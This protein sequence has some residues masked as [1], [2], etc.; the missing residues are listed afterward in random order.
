MLK[1]KTLILLSALLCL[2][3]VCTACRGVLTASQVGDLAYDVSSLGNHILYVK[4]N[5]TYVPFL[6]MTNDFGGN[7]LLLREEIMAQ[8]RPYND[9]YAAYEDS[10][11]DR[12]L[13]TDYLAALDDPNLTVITTRIEVTDP[14]SLGRSGRDTG[15]IDR[16]VFILSH[17]ELALSGPIN[18]ADEGLPLKYFKNSASR[19][20]YLNGE[21]V[22]WWLR[23]P[24]TFYETSVYTVSTN[25]TVGIKED[26]D[27][28]GVRPAFCIP[29]DTPVEKRSDIIDG[30]TVYVLAS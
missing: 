13:N 23:T 17:H 7:T 3:L 30:K 21:A 1:K 19:I 4:E 10:D 25:A 22:E 18:S 5:G 20:A 6:V 15:F 16:D 9:G 26:T 28:S 12:W 2:L 27:E 29:S 14:N 24:D 8:L 11:L